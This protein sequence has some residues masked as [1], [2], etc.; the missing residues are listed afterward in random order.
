MFTFSQLVF[1][2][3]TLMAWWFSNPVKTLPSSDLPR[4]PAVDWFSRCYKTHMYVQGRCGLKRSVE[5]HEQKGLFLLFYLFNHPSL[6]L[7][8]IWMYT[9]RVIVLHW[10]DFKITWYKLLITSSHH[11]R[12]FMIF[13]CSYYLFYLYFISQSNS[14]INLIESHSH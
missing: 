13:N 12:L 2:K 8:C 3:R 10:V 9:A 11:F 6:S 1:A 4:V 7:F 5:G 14:F